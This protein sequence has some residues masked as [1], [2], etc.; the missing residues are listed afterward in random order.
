MST[1][2]WVD[3]G[4]TR[5][6]THTFALRDTTSWRKGC[7]SLGHSSHVKNLAW[8]GS[9]VQFMTQAKVSVSSFLVYLPKIAKCIF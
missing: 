5:I 3:F 4:D 1:C 7:V 2:N 8:K 6:G 9:E